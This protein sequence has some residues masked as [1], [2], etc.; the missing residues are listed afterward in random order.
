MPHTDPKN[1]QIL[2][3]QKEN[4][5][6][7]KQLTKFGKDKYGLF[8]FDVPE[9][10]EN[11]VENML[12]IL[13]EVP[14][15]AIKS[16]DDKPTHI[17]I[18]GDNYHALTCLNYTHKAK[19]DVIYIDPPY[20]TGSDGFKY[21][22]KRI[23]DKYPDGTDVPK[24]SPLRHS[25]WLSFMKKRLEL[26]RDVLRDE[27]II[28]IN[29]D[30]NELA[31]LKLLCD[32]IFIERNLVAI[33]TW[34]R[35]RK[36]SHLDLH[37][38]KNTEFILCYAKNIKKLKPLK[39]SPAEDE[40][41]YP[42][43]NSGNKK[44][45]LS[46]PANYIKVSSLPDGIYQ[47]KIFK[48]KKTSVRLLN[49]IIIKKGLIVSPFKLEGE[50]RYSQNSL[51][52]LL[53][54]N[55]KIIIKGS[56]FKP[57][58]IRELQGG[59]E[60][61]KNTM[62]ILGSTGKIRRMNGKDN[63]EDELLVGTNEDAEEELSSI[64]I[65]FSNPKPVSLIRFLTKIS[66]I[67]KKDKNAIVLDFF[68]G[69]GTTGE[70]VMKL[71]QEDDGKR[72]FILVTNNDE[73]VNGKKYRIMTDVCY[74]RIKNAIK[75]SKNKKPL[76]NSIKYFKTAFVGKNNILNATDEDKIELAHN[77]GG[78]LAIAENTLEL[79]RQNR[80]YQ[81][82]EDKNKE[83]NTAV[84]FREELSKFE[85]FT[86]MVKGL[87]KKTTVYVFSWGDEEFSD[88]FAYFKDVRVKTIPQPI[89]EIYKNI[90]N[91]EV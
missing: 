28:F 10:F 85:E 4:E 20:N 77:A 30:E 47:P 34:I 18:E 69:S 3:L 63:L 17:L 70:A 12:P 80:Y 73:V 82:F 13:E 64:G 33:F 42:F 40:K 37:I 48:D 14:K 39:S 78:L 75:G 7:K 45:I 23:L 24:D 26:A 71:N 66:T 41:P 88:D 21:K 49:K 55:E 56:K 74:P 50:W 83:R 91:L 57:Y 1:N 29:I 36:P 61:L 51:N 65:K 67:W 43:Y 8:W 68:A 87:K 35:K 2:K 58:F 19:I 60:E 15:L 38:R 62:T 6:L 86:K 81:L 52:E 72:Q 53:K 84:Y 31:Q 27:G 11:D 44:A 79:V 76:G 16:R 59:I 5:R 22:D 89:L 25:Y 54:N 9:G 32:D 46:F 90:Y